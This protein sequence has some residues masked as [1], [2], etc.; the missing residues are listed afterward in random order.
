MITKPIFKSAP[1]MRD[2]ESYRLEAARTQGWND[3]MNFI[4]A[5]DIAEQ[6]VQDRRSMM[7]I[8]RGTEKSEV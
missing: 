3:A 7:K 6:E 2:Y 5:E 4:F 1:T 8:V